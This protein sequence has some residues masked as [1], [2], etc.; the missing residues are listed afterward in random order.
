[1]TKTKKKTNKKQILGQPDSKRER[2]LSERCEQQFLVASKALKK[3]AQGRGVFAVSQDFAYEFR[4]RRIRAILNTVEQAQQHI[5]PICWVDSQEFDWKNC[6]VEVNALPI[7]SYDIEEESSHLTQAAAIW[8]LD[9]LER[10][11]H[12]EEALNLLPS[13]DELLD[14]LPEP[15]DIWDLR[16]SNEVLSAMRQVILLRNQDC[17]G[18]RKKEKNICFRA[19]MDEATVAGKQHQD[20]PSRNRWESL[21]ALI[22][23]KRKQAAVRRFSAYFWSWTEHYFR[24]RMLFYDRERELLARGRRLAKQITEKEQKQEEKRKQLLLRQKRPLLF[25]GDKDPLGLMQEQQDEHQ[26]SFDNLDALYD[27]MN[28]RMEQHMQLENEISRM[29]FR[30]S[31]YRSEESSPEVIDNEAFAEIW[32]GFSVEEPY[33]ACFALLLLVDRDSDLPWLYYPG[34]NLIEHVAKQ[35]PWYFQ[36]YE[37]EPETDLSGSS[38]AQAQAG[39]TMDW[40]NKRFSFQEQQ[41]EEEEADDSRNLAQ[42][43]YRMTGV[44]IPRSITHFLPVEE[45]L[46]QFDLPEE[47]EAEQMTLFVKLLS[48]ARNRAELPM[49]LSEEEPEEVA[50]DPAEEV[51]ALRER[52][53]Q[54]KKENDRLKSVAYEAGRGLREAKKRAEEQEKAHQLEHQELVSIRE[55]VFAQGEQAEDQTKEEVPDSLTFPCETAH[56][57][58]SFGGHDSWAREIRKKLPNVRFVDRDKLPNSETI[59]N[60]DMVWVQSNS[61]SH[62]YYYKIID[63][64]RRYSIPV[65]YYSYASAGKCAEQLVQA[66]RELP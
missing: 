32:N 57:I 66:D 36:D 35:L 30:I 25:E 50:V 58:V 11:G 53:A 59:R 44:L 7:N 16:Y 47:E 13:V 31:R 43:L 33:E 2:T 24:C 26:H 6:W 55:L 64:A 39:K 1:M 29:N 38:D 27:E 15:P 46:R 8:M 52:L 10:A 48:Q 20:V 40:Y 61:L 4:K 42:L 21:L 23:E 56:R 34:T 3:V 5:Q 51:A 28:R 9:E 45:K 22:P 19:F 37:P 54:L 18:I 65:R 62:A 41:A 14:E 12:L 60:A 63:E 17:Q 49:V